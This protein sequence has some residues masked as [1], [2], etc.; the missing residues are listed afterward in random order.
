M[1]KSQGNTTEAGLRYFYF[2]W[3]FPTFSENPV[4]ALHGIIL[5][6]SW[7]A[8]LVFDREALLCAYSEPATS[9]NLEEQ[10]PGNS[11]KKNV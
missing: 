5:I 3:T 1:I 9:R 11:Q 7:D 8:F 4:C 10:L 6:W 2:S